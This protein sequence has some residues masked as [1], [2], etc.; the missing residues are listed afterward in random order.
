MPGENVEVVRAFFEAPAD[1]E[2]EAY[3]ADDPAGVRE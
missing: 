1:G 3:L 2:H